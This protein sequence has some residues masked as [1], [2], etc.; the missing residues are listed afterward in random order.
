MA[1]ATTALVR[2][3]GTTGGAVMMMQTGNS[4]AM[5]SFAIHTKYVHFFEIERNPRKFEQLLAVRSQSD[6]F[7]DFC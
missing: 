4:I 1:T 6:L 2:T 5:V 7:I 3:A